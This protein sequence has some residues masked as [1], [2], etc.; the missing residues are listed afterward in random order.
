[1]SATTAAA[2]T[3][4]VDLHGRTPWSILPALLLGFFMIM[5]DTTIVNI[6]IPTLVDTFDVGLSAVGWVTSA[7]LLTYAVLLL[8][9]GRLGDRYG[10]K[11]VFVLGLVVFTLTSA[12]CGL[13]GSIG[14][15]IVARAAQ[16][17]GAALMTPQTMALITRV[18][19][20]QQRGAAMGT[21]GAVAGIATITGPVLGGL[22]VESWGWEWIFFVNVPV[23]IVALVFA[24][25]TLPNLH[26]DKRS[27]DVLGVVLS[28]VGL[29]ALVFGLQEGE[30]YDWGTVWG[31]VSVPLLIAAGLL[32]IGVFLVW[33]HRQG[34]AALLPLSLFHHRNF[35]SRTSAA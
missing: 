12:W 3:G 32:V 8:V 20:P 29:S 17:V 33:Q 19:P 2:P 22:F 10:P 27:F 5:V 23:G 9:A 31:P 28:V 7:Y 35:S 4:P 24:F 34:P 16:G 26:T 25:R 18:F 21:W 13:S 15:L 11:Q 6:A 14:M 30:T 1:M